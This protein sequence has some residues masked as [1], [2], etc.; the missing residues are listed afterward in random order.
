MT[1]NSWDTKIHYFAKLI[2]LTIYGHVAT[3]TFD[4]AAFIYLANE[5]PL[6]LAL[7]F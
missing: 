6:R 2:V 3:T 1:L 7:T 5:K 4:D